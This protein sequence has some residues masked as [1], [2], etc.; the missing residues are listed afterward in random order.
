M[1][2]GKLLD[3]AL[4]PGLRRVFDEDVGPQQDVAV[5]FG[6]AGAV[7]ADRVDVHARADHVVGQDGGVLLVGGA[8]S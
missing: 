3:L 2:G 7:A 5:Q 8:R 4:D 1:V 6:L